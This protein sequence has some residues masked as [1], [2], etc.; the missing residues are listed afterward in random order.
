MPVPLRADFD[1]SAL[2]VIARQ[3]KD[4]PQ[5]RRLLALP[6]FTTERPGLRPPGL[7]G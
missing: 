4:G 6:R 7:A 3:A 5:T 1:A 2:R